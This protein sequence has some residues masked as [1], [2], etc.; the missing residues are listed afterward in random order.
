MA[1]SKYSKKPEVVDAVQYDGTNSQEVLDFAP[2]VAV[3][4]DEKLK[5]MEGPGY[6]VPVDSWVL[7]DFGGLYSVFGSNFLDYYRPGGGP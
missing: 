6:E 3:F 1:V 7:K 5:L 2:G 4:E